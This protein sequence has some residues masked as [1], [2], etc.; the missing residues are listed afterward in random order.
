MCVVYTIYI[1]CGCACAVYACIVIYNLFI[2][3]FKYMYKLP[4]MR[5]IC[6]TGIRHTGAHIHIYRAGTRTDAHRH[7]GPCKRIYESVN[8]SGGRYHLHIAFDT[9]LTIN[10]ACIGVSGS[11]RHQCE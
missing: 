1:V 5:S 2:S 9:P 11:V 8:R 10:F 7:T 4:A 6:G 3:G